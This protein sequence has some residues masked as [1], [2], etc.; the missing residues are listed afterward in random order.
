M[1]AWS[2]ALIRQLVLRGIPVILCADDYGLRDDIDEAILDLCAAGK[3]TAV[4]CMAA[5]ERCEADTLRRLLRHEAVVDVGLHL[6]L[7]DEGLAW[8]TGAHSQT[9][10]NRAPSYG[11]LLKASL[12]G[13]VRPDKCRQ[14]IAAQYGLFVNKCGR[15][16]DHIDG[17]LHAHQLPGVRQG[18]L[19]FVLSLPPERRPYIRNTAMPMRSLWKGGLPWAKASLIGAFGT[20]MKERLRKAGVG[21]NHGFA[22]VYD[23]RNWRCYPGYLPRFT[24]C[25]TKPTGILVVHPGREE[26]W[27]RQEYATLKEF[28]FTSGSLNRFEERR[29]RNGPNHGTEGTATRAMPLPR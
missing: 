24:A 8:S 10:G 18:L 26:D 6:C 12:T 20:V 29:S 9:H 14:E 19:E 28:A 1:G 17:H 15:S 5:L 7:T 21:T 11:G 16:P 27:R 4:S 22:G 23:F 3:L 2:A 25:L 13:R